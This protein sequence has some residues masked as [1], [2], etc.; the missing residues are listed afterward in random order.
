M[1]AAYRVGRA[2]SPAVPRPRTS[3]IPTRGTGYLVETSLLGQSA[4]GDGSLNCNRESNNSNG[5]I[6]KAARSPSLHPSPSCE[7]ASSTGLGRVRADQEGSV[8]GT[9]VAHGTSEGSS[10]TIATSWFSASRC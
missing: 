9:G 5:A 2:R 7:K 10:S 6:T 1:I 8:A 4:G 3:N